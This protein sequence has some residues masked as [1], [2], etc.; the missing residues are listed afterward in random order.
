MPHIA[1]NLLPLSCIQAGNDSHK[2]EL[3]TLEAEVGCSAG[4]GGDNRGAGGEESG[5]AGLG[6]RN[7]AEVG[8]GGSD[9][10]GLNASGVLASN[11]TEGGN[12]TD[13]GNGSTA[14]GACGGE[15]TDCWVEATF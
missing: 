11:H 12:G 4:C 6:E 14:E 13:G 2:E 5:N 10:G 8:G 3:Q 15:L 7:D 1:W 9:H